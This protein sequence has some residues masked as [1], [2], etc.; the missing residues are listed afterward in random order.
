MSL[1]PPVAFSNYEI[2]ITS[3]EYSILEINYLKIRQVK[4]NLITKKKNSIN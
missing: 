2:E 4:R 3:F 1:S